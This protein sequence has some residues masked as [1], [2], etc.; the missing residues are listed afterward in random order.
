MIKKPKR[1][2]IKPIRVG[3]QGYLTENTKTL[4][5]TPDGMVVTVVDI[6]RDKDLPCPIVIV[7]EEL[8]VDW[9]GYITEDEIILITWNV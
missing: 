5:G 6:I 7:S 4:F 3:T 9:R 2:S 1:Y 8:G